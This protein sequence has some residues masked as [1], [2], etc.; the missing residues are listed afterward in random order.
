MIPRKLVETAFRRLWVAVIPVLAVP[1]LVLLLV[2]H[3]SLYEST[4]TAWVSRPPNTTPAGSL[5]PANTPAKAQVQVI[6]DLLATG[7]FRESVAIEAGLTGGD[8]S[9]GELDAAAD[10]VA[11]AV[12]AVVVGPNLVAVKASAATG[13]QAQKLAAA[14][15]A[16][17]QAR[18]AADNTRELQTVVD[19]FTKQAGLAQDE[20]AKTRASLAAYL[21]A[22][23]GV[24]KTGTDTD[25]LA[26]QARADAQAKTVDKLSQSLQDA[27]LQAAAGSA[28]A[29]DTTFEVQDQP[30][31][32]SAALGVPAS[33]RLG[34]PV[35]G[36]F[37]GVV[38]AVVYLYLAYRADHSIRSKD[39]LAGLGLPVLGYVPNLRPRE[40]RLLGGYTPF[41]WI[42][43]LRKD[44]GRKVAASISPIPEEKRLAS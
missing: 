25:F 35:A 33:K 21:K 11:R 1:A 20:L 16:R 29:R 4:G 3:T 9:R 28:T 36:L 15:L 2:H 27:Q 43:P 30:R 13:E 34:Y 41:R 32:P 7:S 26:I 38:I 12:A 23:P 17:Y 22:H 42:A 14:M 31:V 8:A 18:A 39:D 44:Y 6:A 10:A 19:Y 5:D 40:A 37:L 24:D